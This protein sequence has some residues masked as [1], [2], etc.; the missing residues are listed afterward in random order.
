MRTNTLSETVSRYYLRFAVEDRPG[1]M[2]RIAGALGDEG[3]SIEQIVQ[4]GPTKGSGAPAGGPAA[5]E[6]AVDVVLITHDAP[7]GLVR[8]ALDA[9]AREQF[10]REPVHLFRIEEP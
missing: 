1:V 7:E 3:V 8:S 6:P 10:L 4:Q 2:G 9:I 5:R